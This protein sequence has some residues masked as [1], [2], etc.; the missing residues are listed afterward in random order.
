MKSRGAWM[1][2]GGVL[3]IWFSPEAATFGGVLVFLAGVAEEAIEK[4]RRV[5]SGPTGR[6][7]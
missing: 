2:F 5:G 1:A 7:E 6:I 4:K 3:A